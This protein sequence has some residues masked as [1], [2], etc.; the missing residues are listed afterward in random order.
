MIPER[1][2]PDVW[3]Q[4]YCEWEAKPQN[5]PCFV[6][7]FWVGKVDSITSLSESRQ[8]VFV[9]YIQPPRDWCKLDLLRPKTESRRAE[10]KW[11]IQILT[12]KT[13]NF[14]QSQLN[15]QTDF[16]SKWDGFGKLKGSSLDPC[17]QMARIDETRIVT[18]TVN[19]VIGKGSQQLRYCWELPQCEPCSGGPRVRDSPTLLTISSGA[20]VG[21]KRKLYKLIATYF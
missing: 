5:Q 20:V 11:E 21:Q 6:F 19:L 13:S 10:R 9:N 3:S 18:T 7:L 15:N 4:S 2:K 12:P 16:W 17:R 1:R 8:V 14:G